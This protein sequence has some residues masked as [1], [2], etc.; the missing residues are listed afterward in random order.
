M[1]INVF[2]SNG[3]RDFWLLV[4]AALVILVIWD[5]FQKQHSVLR[6]YPLIGHLRY[7]AE[8]LGVYLRRFF[9]ARDREE[10]PFNRTERTWVY[11]AAKNVDTIVGFGSTRNLK[12]M[13]TL[14]F[15]DAPFPVQ[16]QN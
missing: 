15:V 13:G 12:P 6:T 14:Y 4:L 16:G 10:L 9:Y 1:D 5:I 2:L 8:F 3:P 7:I 11:E